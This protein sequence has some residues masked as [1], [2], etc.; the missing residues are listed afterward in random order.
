[1]P[2]TRA[3][4]LLLGLACASV[5]GVALY[6]QTVH[7]LLPCPLC[8]IQRYAYWAIGLTGL[9][10]FAHNPTGSGRRLYSALSG[11]F[12]LSGLG[13]AVRQLWIIEHPVDAGCS[14]SPIETF[15]NNLP[16]A[17][18]WPAMFEANGDCA[19]ASWTLLTL[20]IPEWSAL[21][22]A[23]MALLAA[24]LFLSARSH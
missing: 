19:D 2:T 4:F 3:L 8:V 1:M 24:Y 21:T 23:G 6:L 16:T 20:A 18:L 5:L 15:L 12:A 14:I 17:R 11:L 7:Y 22:F 10:A 13:V 9:L